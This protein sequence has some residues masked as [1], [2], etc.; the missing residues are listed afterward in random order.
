MVSRQEGKTQSRWVVT[1]SLSFQTRS[2]NKTMVAV[3][4][5]N[6]TKHFALQT[7]CTD[8]NAFHHINFS[9][10]HRLREECRESPWV[11]RF[12]ALHRGPRNLPAP[13]LRPFVRWTHCTC[14]L[15]I[16]HHSGTGVT[17]IKHCVPI[18]HGGPCVFV[19]RCRILIGSVFCCWDLSCAFKW[20]NHSFTGNPVFSFSPCRGSH[21]DQCQL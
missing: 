11:K 14:L 4:L 20:A 2:G 19:Y 13:H 9:R 5:L 3:I 8:L 15:S 1:L 10:R 6:P 17:L 16:T 12:E 18:W 7:F 21:S